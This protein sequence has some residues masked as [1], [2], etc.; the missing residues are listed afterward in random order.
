VSDS[1]SNVARLRR[2][3]D[4]PSEIR[5]DD[6]AWLATGILEYLAGARFGRSLDSALSLTPQP[7]CAP[8]WQ[9]ES[10]DERDRLL[11]HIAAEYF[12]QQSARKAATRIR[13]AMSRYSS[14]ATWQKYSTLDAPPTSL[15]P[16]DAD[17]HRLLKTH[18]PIGFETVR[19]LLG[20]RRGLPVAHRLVKARGP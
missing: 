4:H 16:L 12:P 15:S 5:D 7:G 19:R 17:L 20:K 6:A 14:S 1:A 13:A 3:A 18:A 8:W 11:E 9:A 10:R 2:I